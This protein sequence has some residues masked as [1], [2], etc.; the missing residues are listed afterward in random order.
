M[1]LAF[2]S[3]EMVL[4]VGESLLTLLAVRSTGDYMKKIWK[5]NADLL[6]IVSNLQN[7]LRDVVPN[8]QLDFIR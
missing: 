6:V 7:L 5:E 3:R 2:I 1:L 8:T 4:F